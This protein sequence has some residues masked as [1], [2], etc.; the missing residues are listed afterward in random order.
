[1]AV[2]A[3]NDAINLETQAKDTM[4]SSA[5]SVLKALLESSKTKIGEALTSIA[6]AKQNGELNKLTRANIVTAQYSLETARA[7]DSTAISLLKKDSS[8]TRKAAQELIKA[9]ISLKLSAKKIIT[10]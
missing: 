1:L 4:K 2:A 10:K 6:K 5:I 8:Q 9:A 7:L 3:I